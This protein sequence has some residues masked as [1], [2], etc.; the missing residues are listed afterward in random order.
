MST[1]AAIS[2][3]FEREDLRDRSR[4]TPL[5]ERLVAVRRDILGVP[6]E[7]Q[8]SG[9]LLDFVD[10]AVE[11]GDFAVGG[12]DIVPEKVA[13]TTLNSQCL[14]PQIIAFCLE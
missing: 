2:Q 3:R 14:I 5:V 4:A 9:V 7:L 13:D 11:V 6:E 8:T 10:G 12:E 1:T